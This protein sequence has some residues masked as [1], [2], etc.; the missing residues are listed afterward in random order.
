MKRIIE[1]VSSVRQ[2]HVGEKL[3]YVTY[4]G[5]ETPEPVLSLIRLHANSYPYLALLY[6]EARKA[7][8]ILELG[9]GPGRSTKAMLHGCKHGRGG[10]QWSID[11]GRHG[12]T[13]IT[14]QE[15]SRLGLAEY[16]TWMKRD[17][18]KIPVKWYEQNKMD[19][20]WIDIDDANYPLTLSL[21]VAAMHK[22]SKLLLHN[23]DAGRGE[24]EAI[25]KYMSL[26]GFDYEEIDL[27]HGLGILTKTSDN[28]IIKK[29]IGKTH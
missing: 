14:V 7:D 15:I 19:L 11:W 28:S 22:G 10:H 8:R 23:I 12:S 17:A 4:E 27:G 5:E 29:N 21:C 18:E 24:K 25:S 9:V 6:H 13:I 16:F 26:T 3:R 1:T 2:G 20:I